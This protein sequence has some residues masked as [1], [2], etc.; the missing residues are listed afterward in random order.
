MIF[1]ARIKKCGP[2]FF[3]NVEEQLVDGEGC[4]S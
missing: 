1:E 3:R 4:E 2:L